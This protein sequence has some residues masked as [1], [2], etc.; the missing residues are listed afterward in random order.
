[1]FEDF[2]KI[3][4]D[5]WEAK[6]LADLKGK[7]LSDLVWEVEHELKVLPFYHA[8]DFEKAPSTLVGQSPSTSWEVG[9]SFTV[10]DVK[11][12]NKQ[13]LTALNGGVNALELILLRTPSTADLELLFSEVNLDFISSHFILPADSDLVNFIN[14][15]LNFLKHRN[16]DPTQVNGS[17]VK[18]GAPNTEELAEAI[19]FCNKALPEFKLIGISTKGNLSPSD[20]LA[21]LIQQ[22]YQY[23]ADLSDAGISPEIIASGIQLKVS[24]GKSFFVEIAKIRALKLL[25]G[26][27]LKAFHVTPTT[28]V[29]ISA[30]F[31]TGALEQDVNK[32][33]I[34]A[35]TMAMSAIMGGAHRLFVSPGDMDKEQFSRRIARNVQHLL[36]MESF[37]D[38]VDDPGAGSYYI[39]KL[40]R[41]FGEIAWEKVKASV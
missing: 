20:D 19:R 29:S 32:N 24:T 37:L 33:M 5:A 35:A 7:P 1:M 38:K 27:L 25:W 34:T 30:A 31:A 15:W 13:M 41:S 28:P 2:D 11:Q 8:D 18:T 4:K 17:F 36:K 9:E 12:S 22:A 26:N 16:I 3:S 39:E 10:S 6:V 40:T 21:T 23:L 14:H